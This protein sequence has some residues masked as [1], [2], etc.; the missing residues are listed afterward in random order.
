MRIRFAAALI[1]LATS[2][3][4]AVG[5]DDPAAIP[6]ATVRSEIARGAHQGAACGLRAG[7]DNVVLAD[8]IYK[9]HVANLNEKSGTMPFMLGLFFDGWL[10]AAQS[11]HVNHLWTAERVARDFYFIVNDH[12]R[13]LDLDLSAVCEAAERNCGQAMPLW[14]EW[15]ARAA[16]P[17]RVH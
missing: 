4:N 15:R 13:E 7:P 2:H 14:Q 9:A 16:Q 17:M 6:N 10:H 8:C 1:L 12:F 5:L 3:A 11:P